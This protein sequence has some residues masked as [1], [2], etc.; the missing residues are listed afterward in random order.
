MGHFLEDPFTFC[1]KWSSGNSNTPLELKTRKRPNYAISSNL[2]IHSF[3]RNFTLLGR[4]H[5]PAVCVGKGHHSTK[6]DLSPLARHLCWLQLGVQGKGKLIQQNNV[7]KHNS[8]LINRK[9]HIRVFSI[10]L[11]RVPHCILGYVAS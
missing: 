4:R 7:L 9:I 10:N 11:S 3:T 5:S 1:L 2:T 6:S 8:K